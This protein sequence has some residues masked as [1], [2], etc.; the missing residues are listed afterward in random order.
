MRKVAGTQ[1]DAGIQLRLNGQ[2]ELQAV[3]HGSHFFT[4]QQV[5]SADVERAM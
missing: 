5:H 3:Q 2:E 4:R 1:S